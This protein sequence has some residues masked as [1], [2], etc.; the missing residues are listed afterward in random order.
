MSFRKREVRYVLGCVFILLTLDK[1]R[2]LTLRIITVTTHARMGYCGRFPVW[3]LSRTRPH[4][5]DS[6]QW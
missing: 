3:N 2:Q 1:Q 4:R 5:G 6:P